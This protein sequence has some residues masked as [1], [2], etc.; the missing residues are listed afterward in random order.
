MDRGEVE[1]SCVVME[2]WSSSGSEEEEERTASSLVDEIVVE[3]RAYCN[4]NINNNNN[5]K[6]S[7]CQEVSQGEWGADEAEDKLE[8]E[9]RPAKLSIKQKTR[10]HRHITDLL[11]MT[12]SFAVEF[13]D[14]YMMCVAL[15]RSWL[16]TVSASVRNGARHVALAAGTATNDFCY[17]KLWCFSLLI[18]NMEKQL[19]FSLWK[20]LCVC[21]CVR[22]RKREGK[23]T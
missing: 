7:L 4:S 16:S 10:S 6:D 23:N 11:S 13:A 17:C 12:G 21:L 18:R 15:P 20:Y 8:P 22:G 2:V 5:N 19:V 14:F 9:L 3:E 1:D